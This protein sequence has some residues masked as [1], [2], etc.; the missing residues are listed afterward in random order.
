MNFGEEEQESFVPIISQEASEWNKIH[1]KQK[2]S[3]QREFAS[4]TAK[5]QENKLLIKRTYIFTYTYIY[6]FLH[7][8]IAIKTLQNAKT[9]TRSKNF[10]KYILRG[11]HAALNATENRKNHV[12]HCSF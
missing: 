6:G 8:Y 1:S 11:F 2:L 10:S 3:T 4:K 12:V 5:A 9:Y 7:T